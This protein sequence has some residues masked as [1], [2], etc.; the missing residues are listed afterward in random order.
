[1]KVFI[2]HSS[3]DKPYAEALI[4]SIGRDLVTFDEYSFEAGEKLTDNIKR[5]IEGCDIFVLLISESSIG[6]IWVQEEVDMVA[7]RMITKGLV[8]AP[9]CIDDRVK[10]KDT[11]L[12]EW[13]WE[14]LVTHFPHH[15]I[16]ARRIQRLIREQLWKKYP[17]RKQFEGVFVGRGED[18]SRL[19]RTFYK[20][21][22]QRL[23]TLFVSGFP[24]V[25]R[26]TL[27]SHFI[28]NNIKSI[29]D[30]YSPIVI[31]LEKSDSI[32][33]LAL[34]LNEHLGM[35]SNDKMLSE[36]CKGSKVA[37]KMCISI[38]SKLIDYGEKI[39]VEDDAS[40]VRPG[41]GVEKWFLELIESKVFPN[42]TLFFVASRYRPNQSFVGSCPTMAEIS[43][44]TLHRE[45]MFSLFKH[46]LAIG[47]KMLADEDMDTFVEFFTGYPRQA[48]D[49]AEYLTAHNIISTKKYVVTSRERYD[50]NYSAVLEELSEDARDM[51]VLLSRFDFVSCD[52]LQIIYGDKDISYLLDEL[53]QFSL[54]ETFGLS[55][56]YISL[57]TAVADYLMRT[58][59]KLSPELKSKLNEATKR[60][61]AET[62]DGLTDLSA[63]L[64]NI[65]EN[66]RNNLK[67]MDER[68]LIPSFALK[69]ILEEY[70]A[71]HDEEVVTIA[72]KLIN[73]YHQVNYESCWDA[74]Y[75]WLCC[76][77]CRLQ[78]RESFY[79]Y[80]EHFADKS[81]DYNYLQ[82]FYCRQNGKAAQLK[83]AY[84]Y[85]NIARELKEESR[86]SLASIAK[87]EHEMVIVLMKLK[88]YKEALTYA[89]RNYE[90]NQ[91]N[92]YHI[93]AFFNC[94]IHTQSTDWELM[95]NLITAM[96][97]AKE[98]GSDAFGKAM[99]A[100]YNY[101][102]NG[103]FLHAVK[104][105]T[106]LVQGS[107]SEVTQYALDVFREICEKHGRSKLFEELTDGVSGAEDFDE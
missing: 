39:I 7:P 41:G 80:L 69:V 91:H 49:T 20:E 3:V 81:F 99:E 78:R 94:L 40:I 17:E 89:K 29:N 25:G 23:R 93:R 103:D 19:E 66:I 47:G 102:K 28:Q 53:E 84:F 16:L 50:G 22:L 10:M 35:M 15:K 62:Q 57:G 65:K 100:Q 13:V 38:L 61:L 68:Y 46:C 37:M 70:H 92:S 9:Y 12:P 73:D 36:V 95:W 90:N 77:L 54:F 34:M 87:V 104:Q 85:Y 72:E 60:V 43:L 63:S 96:K 52:L 18:M 98:R 24:F 56:Q 4:E 8:F 88:N 5:G 86:F 76:S 27:L 1:M 32:E 33:Q 58:R 14:R 101:Q 67:G 105:F 48:I 30:Y 74:I 71:K 97:T 42:Q 82:G 64:F 31:R 59:R 51:L 83:K 107:D 11:R 44:S 106:P 75:Y 55:N 45:D 26:K 79:K 21:D 2:S 6:S